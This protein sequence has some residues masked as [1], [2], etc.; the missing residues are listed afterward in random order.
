MPAKVTARIADHPGQGRAR[1]LPFRRF[2]G[3]H[4]VGDRLDAGQRRAAGAE[5]PQ[6]D[7]ERQ[8]TGARELRRFGR[9]LVHR[10]AI[11]RVAHEPDRD[12][13]EDADQEEVGRHGE[14]AAGLA[15]AAQVEHR[16]QDDEADAERD[17]VVVQLRE[18][19][20]PAPPPPP[21]C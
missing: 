20:R 14:D 15:D 13:H 11:D 21:R 4:A 5:R 19:P 16:H 8:R 7:E 3:G 18:R 17:A 10:E 1:V 6:H 2:E 9:R 12:Q